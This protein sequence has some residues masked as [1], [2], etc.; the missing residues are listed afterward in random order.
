[1]QQFPKQQIPSLLQRFLYKLRCLTVFCGCNTQLREM[2]QIIPHYICVLKTKILALKLILEYSRLCQQLK[3][4]VRC[5]HFDIVAMVPSK[6][7][8]LP[9]EYITCLA[10]S[11]SDFRYRFAAYCLEYT[12]FIFTMLEQSL[13]LYNFITSFA[14]YLAEVKKT[15][16]KSQNHK[17]TTNG[18]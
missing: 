3:C 7:M 1:M 16:S 11:D 14:L 6:Q 13:Q 10:M 9:R 18:V 4:M 2:Y 12:A 5:C 15:T 17:P 8:Q